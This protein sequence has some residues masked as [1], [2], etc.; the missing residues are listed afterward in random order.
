MS[1][2]RHRHAWSEREKEKEGCGT[3]Y[4]CEVLTKIPSHTGFNISGAWRGG[5]QRRGS[6]GG[7]CR[8][9]GGDS[10]KL[11]GGVRVTVSVP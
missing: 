4:L 9:R 1:V 10:G 6:N 11:S 8:A 5:A 3:I 2:R 7:K